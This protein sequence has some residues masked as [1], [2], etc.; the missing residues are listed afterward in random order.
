M[1]KVFFA[2]VMAAVML[3]GCSGVKTCNYTQSKSL[4]YIASREKQTAELP[5]QK[6]LLVFVTE[7]K[8][9]VKF[10]FCDKRKNDS[11]ALAKID[12]DA[13]AAFVAEP[14]I[15]IFQGESVFSVSPGEII[16]FQCSTTETKRI[17]TE[18]FKDKFSHKDLSDEC[19]GTD[20]IIPA[21]L[22]VPDLVGGAGR[23]GYYTASTVGYTI[24]SPF[25]VLY[26]TCYLLGSAA[27]GAMHS[28]SPSGIIGGAVVYSLTF[29]ALPDKVKD[30]ISA[31]TIHYPSGRSSSE[32]YY[33]PVNTINPG[34]FGPGVYQDPYGRPVR[35]EVENGIPG[36]SLQIQHNAYGPGVG[37]DQYGRPVR[38]VPAY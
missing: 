28:G 18:E 34:D 38:T 32:N 22:K 6:S 4:C 12:K 8:S 27:K 15:Y 2:V 14:G 3:T 19:S 33:A 9:P 23:F 31:G 25:Y 20:T 24:L 30:D 35:Y 16:I 7:S 29:W 1:M 5:A 36:E 21:K 13:F 26:G 17:S 10:S 11:K 37:M